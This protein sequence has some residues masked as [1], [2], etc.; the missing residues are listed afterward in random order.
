MIN[1]KC[2]PF[3]SQKTKDKLGKFFNSYHRYRAKFSCIK[4]FLEIDEKKKNP[5]E[6]WAADI[7]IWFTEK[8]T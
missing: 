7:N 2:K 8:K 3:K 5:I 6:T 4:R 1:F